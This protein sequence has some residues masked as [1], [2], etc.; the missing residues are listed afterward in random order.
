[1]LRGKLLCREKVSSDRDNQTR[2]AVLR[3]GDRVNRVTGGKLNCR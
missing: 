1:L 3:A 2:K